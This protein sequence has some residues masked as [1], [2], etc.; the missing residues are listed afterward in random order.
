MIP[1]LKRKGILAGLS[2]MCVLCSINGADFVTGAA[3]EGEKEVKGAAQTWAGEKKLKGKA[4]QI[5]VAQN[6]EG[7]VVVFYAGTGQKLYYD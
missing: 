5:A 2:L 3:A 1:E 6:L 7:S 4:T